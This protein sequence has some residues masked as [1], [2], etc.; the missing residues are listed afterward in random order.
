MRSTGHAYLPALDG[1][2]A[3]SI[4]LVMLSHAWLGEIIPGGLGVTVFFFISGFIITRLMLSEHAR[5][6][7]I[8]IQAFY[9]RRLFRLMPALYVFVAVSAISLWLSGAPVPWQDVA[10]ALFYFSNYWNICDCFDS[11]VMA[12]PLSIT[13]SLAVEEHYYFVFPLLFAV[14]APRGAWLTRVIVGALFAVLAWRIWLASGMDAQML[15]G[16]RIYMGTDTR[17]DSIFYGAAFSLLTTDR[18]GLRAFLGRPAVFVAGIALMLATLLY[19]DPFF[20]ETLRF[21]LQGIALALMF[22]YLVFGQNL[23]SRILASRPLVHVGLISY[24]LYLYHWLVFVLLDTWIPDWPLALRI[25]LLV[26]LSFGAAHL[27]WRHVERIG[28]ALRERM[29]G[30]GHAPAPR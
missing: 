11:S 3:A 2:R 19:R 7:G 12:S 8:D 16:K 25:G 10:A 26:V 13:W 5:D 4:L 17:V 14:L 9:V 24:S 18:P 1:L 23:F 29:R 22:Q 20:R 27:S 28:L 6:G 30:R 21:S 15:S